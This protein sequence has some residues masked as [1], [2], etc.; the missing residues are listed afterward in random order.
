MK[1]YIALLRGINVSG[2]KLM[3][4]D[5]LKDLFIRLKYTEVNTYLQSGNIVFST[6]EDDPNLIANKIEV[7]I[8]KVYDFEV[9]VLI[10]PMDELETIAKNHPFVHHFDKDPAYFHITFLRSLPI[11]IDFKVIDKNVQN[12]EE[13]VIVEK[14][15]YLY[16]PNG[17]GRTKLTNNFFENKLNV[18]ATTRNWKTCNEL[19]KLNLIG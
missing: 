6:S 4:M 9:P 18:S 17:Y 14:V 10:L 1:R 7:E 2:Q 15:I 13:F 11:N 16:C 19:L 5:A 8:L 3:K 12:E